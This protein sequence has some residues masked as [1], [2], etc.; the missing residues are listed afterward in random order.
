VPNSLKWQP[1]S[2]GSDKR[3][4]QWASTHDKK[5]LY[6]LIADGQ[7]MGPASK[8]SQIS[9]IQIRIE[10]RRLWPCKRYIFESKPENWDKSLIRQINVEG[11]SY[12]VVR[13]PFENIGSEA[14]QLAP[15]RIDLKVGNNSW[16]PVHPTT[17]RLELGTDNPADLGWLVFRDK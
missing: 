4:I 9:G 15:L 1:C 12:A 10:P 7:T 8:L 5:A 14:E 3:E 13:I 6:L 16:R 2:Y 11:K 17:S